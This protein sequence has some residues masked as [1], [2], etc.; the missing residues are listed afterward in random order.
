M[1]GDGMDAPTIRGSLC[2]LA[3]PLSSFSHGRLFLTL[4]SFKVR[5]TWRC[6]FGPVVRPHDEKPALPMPGDLGPPTFSLRMLGQAFPD[7]RRIRIA[8]LGLHS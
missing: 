5:F 7:Q 2:E 3:L 1:P 6:S 8:R 4:D